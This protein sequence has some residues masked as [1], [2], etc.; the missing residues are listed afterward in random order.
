MTTPHASDPNQ[1]L[2]GSVS[3]FIQD[4]SKVYSNLGQEIIIT[5]EDKIRLCLIEHLSRMET[6]NAWIAPLGILLTIII[7]FPTTTFR[8]FLFLSAD[9]W[10]AI[11]VIGGVIATA[12]LIKC[13][14]QA[15]AS[16]SLADV[17]RDI[18]ATGIMQNP[19]ISQSSDWQGLLVSHKW[20]LIFKPP[21][22]SK[23]IS[24]LPNGAIGE[25]RIRT[26]IHG[27]F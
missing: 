9:S 1:I 24:F 8:E 21:D 19:A 2:M 23:P 27:V 7:V 16:S 14:L 4:S 6:R 13:V 17:V 25:G 22:Q 20:I 11:F 5:T 26:N 3:Q 15:R 18:K 10:R 12:W